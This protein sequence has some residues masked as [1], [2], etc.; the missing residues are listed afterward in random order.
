MRYIFYQLYI[1]VFFKAFAVSTLTVTRKIFVASSLLFRDRYRFFRTIP[2]KT[3][4]RYFLSFF[5]YD[6]RR[7]DIESWL[8]QSISS[9]STARHRNLIKLSLGIRTF[10]RQKYGGLNVFESTNVQENDGCVS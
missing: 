9:H 10:E 1:S 2:S 4:T 5:F 3:F 6:I 8:V 7:A